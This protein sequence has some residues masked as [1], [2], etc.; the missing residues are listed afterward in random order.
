MLSELLTLFLEFVGSLLMKFVDQIFLLLSV[1]KITKFCPVFAS[2][3][4]FSNL[5]RL[6]MPEWSRAGGQS[7]VRRHAHTRHQ[8]GGSS[9]A[10]RRGPC[11]DTYTS[12][13]ATPC[14]GDAT[15]TT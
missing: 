7:R 3:K 10:N 5:D 15:A 4:N 6:W 12:A 14:G 2:T 11:D 9:A 1:K 13:T 8:A